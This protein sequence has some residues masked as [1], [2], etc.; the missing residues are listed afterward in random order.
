MKSRWL[1]DFA[2][3]PA[4]HESLGLLNPLYGCFFSPGKHSWKRHIQQLAESPYCFPALQCEGYC[5]RKS[6]VE[7][8]R[9]AS[10]SGNSEP[11][12][13]PHSCK[14]CGDECRRQCLERWRGV[15]SHLPHAHS[16]HFFGL[17]RRQMDLGEWQWI[18][19]SLT[20]CWQ[21]F[22]PLYQRWFHYWSNLT[23]P[24]VSGM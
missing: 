4:H 21:Q 6:Q 13:I 7:A 19:M 3:D 5:S 24:L 20:R 17:W 15:D 8:S 9:T 10:T 14:D 18:F 11:I 22:Q 16:A 23:H 1:M 2:F 12:A